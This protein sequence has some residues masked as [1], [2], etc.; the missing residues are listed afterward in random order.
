MAVAAAVQSAPETL[1]GRSPA[2]HAPLATA[3]DTQ[4]Q[5]RKTG[6]AQRIAV[7]TASPGGTPPAP[8]RTVPRKAESHRSRSATARSADHAG[9]RALP[10]ADGV[11]PHRDIRRARAP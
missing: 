1:P 3:R 4:A 11:S 9:L 7:A 2:R 8:P 5:R 10:A 6:A